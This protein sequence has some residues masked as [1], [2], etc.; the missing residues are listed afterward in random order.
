MVPLIE[1]KPVGFVKFPGATL[2]AATAAASPAAAVA[3][4]NG[5]CLGW[6][7][8]EAAREAASSTTVILS[9]R[10]GLG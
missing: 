10:V 4:K 2:S 5:I 8:V 1:A 9:C 7:T 6:N 3:L